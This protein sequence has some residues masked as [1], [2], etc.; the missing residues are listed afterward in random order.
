L[1]KLPHNEADLLAWCFAQPPGTL[2]SLLASAAARSI[3]ATVL[4]HERTTHRHVAC[5]HL[6][7]QLKLDPHS[8]ANIEKLGYFSRTP[9]AH[10][11]DVLS[12]EIPP[13]R[14]RDAARKIQT[15]TRPAFASKRA[16]AY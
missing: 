16:P 15:E 11:L 12:A 14:R 5:D 9:K 2:L 10:I 13:E 6:G 3:N 8:Y 7:E 4:T 1:A